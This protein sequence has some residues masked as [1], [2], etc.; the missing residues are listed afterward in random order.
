MSENEFIYYE[1]ADSNSIL[2]DDSG[3]N[4]FPLLCKGDDIL[5][6]FD[7]PEIEMLENEE[8]EDNNSTINGTDNQN[9]T[10]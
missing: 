10:R 1:C 4:F 5:G 9:G 8:V 6:I 7:F 3:R 2:D